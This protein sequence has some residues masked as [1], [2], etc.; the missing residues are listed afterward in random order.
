MQERTYCIVYLKSKGMSFLWMLSK[1]S[2]DIN[3]VFM[4]TRA[5]CLA[6]AG[7]LKKIRHQ[8]VVHQGCKVDS[9]PQFCKH[10]VCVLHKQH[11][12]E[13]SQRR[14]ASFFSRLVFISASQ[15]WR[16]SLSLINSFY[17]DRNSEWWASDL[18]RWS[19]VLYSQ[20]TTTN[21]LLTASS[22]MCYDIGGVVGTQQHWA[23]QYWW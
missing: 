23:K 16:R 2:N 5:H 4:I 14:V 15:P 18:T 3:N 19:D 20:N 17:T 8:C 12:E 9:S 13:V 6:D 11:A 1:H 21:A 10:K 7:S 22:T